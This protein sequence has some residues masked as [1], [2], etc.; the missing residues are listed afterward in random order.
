MRTHVR[1]IS[2]IVGH[3]LACG[4]FSSCLLA[5][6]AC[7]LTPVAS[8]ALIA[9]DDPLEPLN[10]Q[11]YAFNT[12]VTGPLGDVRDD[13]PSGAVWRGIHNVLVNLREP[14]T[15]ANDLAQ[16][17]DCAAGA[18]LR[19]FMV[20][21]TLGVGGI[22]DVARE[23]GIPAHDNDFGQTLAVWGVPSGPFLVVPILGP[24]DARAAAA[25]AVEF[26]ADP[27]DVAW[28]SV[29]LA[30]VTLPLA[31]ADLLDRQLAGTDDVSGADPSS[32]DSYVAMREAYR[33]NLAAAV[34]DE[35]CPAAAE[36]WGDD[37]WR[38]AVTQS[39]RR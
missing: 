36:G 34:A 21:S 15:F 14:L 18:A 29:G 20:N 22:F 7:G 27:V 8:P 13:A 35:K 24:W 17:R 32:A 2:R 37:G 10:R 30:Q 6:A 9:T 28:R 3:A 11:I 38:T 31:G 1:P 39:D 23:L 26:V 12:T 25:T 33:R 19:R 4:G 5:L 16:G